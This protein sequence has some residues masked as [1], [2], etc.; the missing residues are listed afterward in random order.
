MIEIVEAAKERWLPVAG[1]EGLYEVSDAGNVRSLFRYKRMLKHNVSKRGYHT[2]QLFKG[3]TGKRVLVHRIVAAAFAPNPYNFSQVNHK[4]ENKSNNAAN[5]LE[6]CTAKYNM[7]YGEVAKTR[8]TKIDYSKPIFKEI[9]Y[10]NSMNRRK[11]VLQFTTSGE[12]VKKYDSAAEAFRKTGISQSHI[13]ESCK[14]NAS[15]SAGGF[16]WRYANE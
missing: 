11:S 8:H 13:S 7:N 16:K 14:S 3:K 12:F 10:R 1:Y 6:W 5:N 15:R 9:A 2:V 4:D